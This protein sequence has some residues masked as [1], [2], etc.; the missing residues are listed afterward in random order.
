MKFVISILLCIFCSNIFLYSQTRKEQKLVEAYLK[1]DF[2]T[3]QKSLNKINPFFTYNDESFLLRLVKDEAEN[4]IK[5]LTSDIEIITVVDSANLSALAWAV[6][7]QNFDLVKYLAPKTPK[8]FSKA[9]M[10][11]SSNCYGSVMAL[12]VSKNTQHSENIVKALLHNGADVN[13]TELDEN[14]KDSGMTPIWIAVAQS[15]LSM[16]KLL[17]DSGADVNSSI[18]NYSVLMY[19]VEK[20]SIDIVNML[21]QNGANIYQS[22]ENGKTA[23]SLAIQ[24]SNI[25]ILKYFESIDSALVFNSNELR[26][27]FLYQKDFFVD[28]ILNHTLLFDTICIDNYKNTLQYTLF[29]LSDVNMFKKLVTKGMSIENICLHVMRDYTY[30]VLYF[31]GSSITPNE[32]EIL[33]FCLEQGANPLANF[34]A[35]SPISVAI[36]KQNYQYANM[37]IS[38]IKISSETDAQMF[39]QLVAKLIRTKNYHVLDRLFAKY[40]SINSDSIDY[41]IFANQKNNEELNTILKKYGMYAK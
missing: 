29:V 6:E 33:T 41:N 3:F 23:I 5:T 17:I 24:K 38:Y 28:Y 11:D 37:L 40:K 8:P 7:K 22:M 36:D 31:P 30:S 4:Y 26:I 9:L 32:K 25:D 34:L 14:G 27:A 12:A 20:G 19:A 10:C 35:G 2:T 39:N 15:N 18:N 16:L 1:D 21:V 13:E